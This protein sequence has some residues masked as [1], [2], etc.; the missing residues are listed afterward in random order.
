MSQVDGRQAAKHFRPLSA[1]IQESSLLCSGLLVSVRNCLWGRS[2][3][4]AEHKLYAF[5]FD[6]WDR[7]AILA[8]LRWSS[9]QVFR[10]S[11][12]YAYWQ[13]KFCTLT[14]KSPQVPS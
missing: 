5:R 14:E 9:T 1:H 6:I 8:P 7:D 2:A 3:C 12:C 10:V 11:A 4:I 13:P